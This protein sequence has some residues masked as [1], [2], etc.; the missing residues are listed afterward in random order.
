[1]LAPIVIFAFNRPDA[2]VRTLDALKKNPLFAEST[3]YIFIDGPRNDTDKE[4]INEVRKIAETATPNVVCAEK[5]KGVSVSIIQG[6]SQ[7]V[8]KHGVA[9][10]IEDD[11]CPS[12]G[13]L[14]YMNRAL[15]KYRDDERVFS[16]SGYGLKIKKPKDYRGDV[17]LSV[18]SS[19]WGWATW[20][21]RW[22]TVDWDVKDFKLIESDRRMQKAFNRGGSDMYG[23]LCNYMNGKI[24][25]WAIRFNFSQFLQ[26]K[27]SVIP[28]LSLANNHGFG[29]NATNCKQKYSRFKVE[30]NNSLDEIVLPDTLEVNNGIIKQLQHYHS[31]PIRIYSKI[32]KILNI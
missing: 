29:D 23:M 12:P 27:Y 28:F 30:C 2:L 24:D 10:N 7:I 5:N 25:S 3:T 20:A 4:K 32:R 18:R 14:T 21:D 11:V 19:S 15:E 6:F 26:E 22:N 13:F 31:I 8:N 1:M 9:I 16:I 17:Y